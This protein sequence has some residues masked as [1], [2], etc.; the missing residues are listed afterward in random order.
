MS[1]PAPLP[2]LLGFLLAI[3]LDGVFANTE[4]VIFRAPAAVPSVVA[5][6]PLLRPRA[7]SRIGS[8]VFEMATPFA[9]ANESSTA[10]Q[11]FRITGMQPEW[12]YELRICWPAIVCS[13][14]L[15]DFCGLNA[16]QYRCQQNSCST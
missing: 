1:I 16:Y 7:N 6:L 4:K 13:R 9:K 3:L 11:W 12:T 8:L 10:E 5:N 2:L 15:E 14:C